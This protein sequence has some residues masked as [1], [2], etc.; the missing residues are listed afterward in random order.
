[1]EFFASMIKTFRDLEKMG[2]FA[3]LVRAGSSTKR[4]TILK[5]AQK[6]ESFQLVRI[7]SFLRNCQTYGISLS[8]EKNITLADRKGKQITHKD[9]EPENLLQK[10]KNGQLALFTRGLEKHLP[11]NGYSPLHINLAS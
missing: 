10:Y 7:H 6:L 5:R 1:M 4:I 11:G 8:D 2:S 3:H 9:L